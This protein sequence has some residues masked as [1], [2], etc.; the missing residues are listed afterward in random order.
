MKGILLAILLA[1]G[2]MT[3]TFSQGTVSGN[4]EKPD[5]TMT[6]GS[7]EMQ[8]KIKELLET[9]DKHARQALIELGEI[10]LT[11]DEILDVR[12]LDDG[13]FQMRFM[14]GGMCYTAELTRKKY[15]DSVRDANGELVFSNIY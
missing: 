5:T 13:S 1:V 7:A 3:G 11:P 15:I 9:D 8:E 6:E 14:H 10:D 4:G 12:Q 2:V